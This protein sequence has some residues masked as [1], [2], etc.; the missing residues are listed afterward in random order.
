MVLTFKSSRREELVM[1]HREPDG[2][3]RVARA[4]QSDYNPRHWEVELQHPSGQVWSGTATG[5]KA[6]VGIV[7]TRLMSDHEQ[8]FVQ[9]RARGDRPPAE[10]RD[11]SVR[12]SEDGRDLAP[13]LVPR[14]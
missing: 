6:E 3:Q 13:Q 9:D 14:R 10:N 5:N 8:E 2:R 1:V 4:T 12:I 7:L 11:H